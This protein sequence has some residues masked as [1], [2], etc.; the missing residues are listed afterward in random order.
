MHMDTCRI[1][2]LS[3]DGARGLDLSFVT[4]IYLMDSLLDLSL[5]QQIISRAYRY[6]CGYHLHLSMFLIILSFQSN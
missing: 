1:L 2:L 5:E 3:T 4:H 6:V